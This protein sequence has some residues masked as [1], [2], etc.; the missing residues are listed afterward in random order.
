MT[1]NCPCG[2][3]DPNHYPGVVD[4]RRIINTL[5]LELN[6][7]DAAYRGALEHIDELKAEV[8]QLKTDETVR[9]GPK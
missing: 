1:N 3:T 4:L 8:K 2:C 9:W 6:S 7:A 5:K